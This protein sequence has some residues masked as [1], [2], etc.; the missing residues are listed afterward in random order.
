[1]TMLRAR[2]LLPLLAVA[3]A[4]WPAAASA[5]TPEQVVRETLAAGVY[6][7]PGN[8][9]GVDEAAIRDA[10]RASSEPVFVAVVTDATLQQAG[11]PRGLIPAI[12]SASQDSGSSVVVVSD[13][14]EVF[15]GSGD[16]ALRRG[17]NAGAAADRASRTL[18]ASP[19]GAELTSAV[20]DVVGA[21]DRRAGTG[22]AAVPAQRSPAQPGAGAGVLVGVLALGAAGG[23]A[24]YYRRQRS[25]QRQELD[26]ARADVESLYGRLGSD[27]Q[28]IAAGDDAVARQCLADAAERYNATG[29]LLAKADTP[30]EYAAA[31]RTAVEGL[32]AARTARERLGLD[33]G[34]EI[35][36]PP[37]SGPQL[38]RESRVQV[39]EEEFV[40]SPRYTP[41]R[42]HYYGGGY[43]GGVLVPGGWYQTPFWERAL[44]AGVLYGG[45]PLGAPRRR[46]DDWRRRRGGRGGGFGGGGLG[47]GGGTWGGGSVG[48]GRGRG[49]T[50]GGGSIGGG[51][52]GGGWGG[53]SIGGGRMGGGGRGGG[54]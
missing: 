18:G 16:E 6:V 35:A 34:P 20:L 24:V 2:V 17:V 50:W 28:L 21:V 44:L 45:G 19:S 43:L 53:G 54:W 52:A 32:I 14:G 38:E 27:V 11:G 4:L 36:P 47:G 31:R 41:G 51:R 8:R 37:G 1:M 5:A 25:R 26:E 48:G 33:L 29:A 15:A 39:G 7:E 42:P 9:A 12:G 40:G 22:G 13:G 30:G 10:V 49:G 23:G 46:D 3:V